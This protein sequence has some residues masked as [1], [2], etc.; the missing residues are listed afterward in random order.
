M[1]FHTLLLPAALA[2][3]L[4]S[5]AANAGFCDAHFTFDGNIND[6][7]GNGYEG[8]V[9]GKGGEAMPRVAPSYGDGRSGQALQLNGSYAIRAPLDLSMESCPQVTISAWVKFE[10]NPTKGFEYILSSGRNGPTLLREGT[11]LNA[12]GGGQRYR[13]SKALRGGSWQFIAAAIDHEAGSMTVYWRNRSYVQKIGTVGTK[14]MDIWIGAIG[15]DLR[16][17]VNAGSVDEIRI[18]GQ[19]LTADQITKL[20]AGTTRSPAP[21]GIPGDQF[22]PAK[23]P[24]DQ[25]EPTQIPGDQF[26]PAQIPGDQFEPAQIPGDQFE[27][28]QI[29]GDQFEPA[30]IPGDQ[31]EPTQIPGDQFEP[32]QIPGDQFEQG[33]DISDG[34]DEAGALPKLFGDP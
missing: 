19:L 1:R 21:A 18:F 25:F 6:S 2:C 14:E 12:R 34:T 27:P 26:E 31:F 16:M 10:D 3:F 17:P 22:E 13:A 4:F 11:H 8:V 15:D 9:I 5:G 33:P 20:Q 24:G 23:I 29:P 30:Q 7:S 28:T 32:A